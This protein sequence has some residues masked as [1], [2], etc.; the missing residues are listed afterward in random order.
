MNVYKNL[1]YKIFNLFFNPNDNFYYLI[2]HII[3][4]FEKYNNKKKYF[5]LFSK[6]EEFFA[7]FNIPIK[8]EFLFRKGEFPIIYENFPYFIFSTDEDGNNKDEKDW[9]IEKVS[10]IFSIHFKQ[11]LKQNPDLILPL[12][13]VI[14]KQYK[15]NFFLLHYDLFSDINLEEFGFDSKSLFKF[16]LFCIKIKFFEKIDNFNCV[17]LQ[18]TQKDRENIDLMKELIF[19]II[20]ISDNLSMPKKIFCL[21]IYIIFKIKIF[22]DEKINSLYELIHINCLFFHQ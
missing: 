22:I 6:L 10:S 20:Y 9:T 8:K 4:A 12:I 16:L 7:H 13:Y 11:L 17:V 1:K 21:V 18:K 5:N 3:E 14:F 15:R 2:S 19:F